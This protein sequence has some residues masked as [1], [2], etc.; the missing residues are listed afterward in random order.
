MSGEIKPD[1]R[2]LS[3]PELVNFFQTKHEQPF[4]A[5]QVNEWLWKKGCSSFHTMSN[6]PQPVRDYL[7]ENFTFAVA[8]PE[9]VQKGA[10]GTMKTR[11]RLTDGLFIESVLIPSDGRTTACIS[12]QVGCALGC[13][14]CA[15][16]TIGF[17]RNLTSG[18][19]YDQVWALNQQSVENHKIPLSNIVFMGMGEPLF[20]YQHVTRSIENLT[21]SSGM[22]FS[23][24]RITLSSIGIPKMIRQ[25]ADD[26]VKF[27]FALSLHAANDQK[28][29][30]LIPFNEKHTIQ[31]L[32]NALKYYHQK[33]KKRFTIE[34]L[35]LKEVN[36]SVKD[37]R[38]V[39]G[40]CKSF[41]VKIN[42][43]EYNPVE[44]IPFERSEIKK[45]KAFIEFLER[46]NLIVH[47][48]K[49]RGKDIDAAC[50]Q[51]A[52]KGRKEIHM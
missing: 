42:I 18:E 3:L 43:I 44:G 10:D 40:F 36:D 41:P 7:S 14:F 20:N 5:K 19:I 2:S 49:S 33:T 28:R 48:R 6:V 29:N 17:H 15:T 47:V 31:D 38:E 34:Y 9:Y 24:Q 21:S 50:G 8:T 30:L 12:S 11:F 22:G 25:M 45:M 27:Q 37:A 52:L 35:L 16:A 4:R 1:I 13:K 26:Q 39:A 51:L 46:K 32:T 23:P